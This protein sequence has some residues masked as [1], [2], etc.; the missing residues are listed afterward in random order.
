VKLE[1]SDLNFGY[2]GKTILDGI[3]LEIE[4]GDIVSLVGPN[5]AG[6]STLI[7]CIDRILK[8]VNGARS[9][10]METRQLS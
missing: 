1:V 10:S 6:K 5:G 9:I 2:N 4:K 3:S 7:K 8:T